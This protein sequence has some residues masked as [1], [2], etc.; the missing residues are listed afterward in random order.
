MCWC[1]H[2]VFERRGDDLYTNITLSLVDALAGFTL[3]LTHLDGHLVPVS[4]DKVTW[5]GAKVAKKGEGMPNY[6]NNNVRGTLYITF[7]VNFPKGELSTDDKRGK[8]GQGF[9]KSGKSGG[10]WG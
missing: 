3:D 5:P 2:A 4:R 10:G 6:D 8:G 7:D 1:R 9:H